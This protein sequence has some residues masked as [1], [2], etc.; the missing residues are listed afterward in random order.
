MHYVL[1]YSNSVENYYSLM[2]R[3][4]ENLP[5]VQLLMFVNVSATVG[6]MVQ[7]LIETVKLLDVLLFFTRKQK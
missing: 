7:S 2:P 6:C 1:L 5:L 4:S 3:V